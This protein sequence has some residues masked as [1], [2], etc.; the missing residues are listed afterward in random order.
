MKKPY[1]NALAAAVYISLVV[2]FMH[3]M[4]SIRHDTPDTFIDG[5]GMIS[6]IVFSAAVMGFLFFYQPVVLLIENKKAEAM[7]YFLQTLGTF[8]IVTAIALILVSIQ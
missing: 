6:L 1:L 3:Y 5:L 2:L 4:Q 8:G 7:R